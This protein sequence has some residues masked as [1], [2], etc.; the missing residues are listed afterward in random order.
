MAKPKMSGA[1]RRKLKRQEAAQARLDVQRRL[2]GAEVK[3]LSPELLPPLN[4]EDL[5]SVGAYRRELNRVYGQMRI[6][7]MLPETGT[8]LAFVLCQGAGLA[9]IEQELLEAEAI[10]NELIKLNQAA[11]NGAVITRSLPAPFDSVHTSALSEV[12]Q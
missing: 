2:G 6:G 1:A 10:R 7:A 4:V 5:D 11:G 9:R 8:K 3:P 12:P